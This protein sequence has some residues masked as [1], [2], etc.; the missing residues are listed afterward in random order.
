MESCLDQALAS[1]PSMRSVGNVQESVVR[2]WNYGSKRLRFRLVFQ[3]KCQYR[4]TYMQLPWG[5][6]GLWKGHLNHRH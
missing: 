5:L 3:P 2:L 6:Q 4:A 1:D